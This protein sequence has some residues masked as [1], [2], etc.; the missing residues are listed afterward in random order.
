MVARLAK[1]ENIVAIKDASRDLADLTLKIQLA[2]NDI[3]MFVGPSTHILACV[4]FGA[5][6]FISS[7]PMELMRKDGRRLFDLAV[8]KNIEEGLPLQFIATRL[9]GILFG[10][11]T[12]PA[13]LKAAM[14]ALG[15][16]AGVP[17]LP[18]HRLTAEATAELTRRLKEVGVLS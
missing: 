13:A 11:G 4:S 2:G 9:Y 17:R 7:G 18:V 14:N 1:H 12:W 15:R 6:G 3:N 16:P 5:K 10:I 8:D